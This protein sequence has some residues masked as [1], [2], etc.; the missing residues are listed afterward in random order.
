MAVAANGEALIED[1]EDPDQVP[2]WA[3]LWPAARGMAYYLWKGPQLKGISALELGAGAGLPGVVC[4]LKGAR[5]V[6]SDFQPL[7]LELCEINARLNGLQSYSLLLEDWR[8]YTGRDQFDLVLA[9]DIAYEPRLLPYL[10][11]VLL[12]VL[13]PGGLLYISHDNRP[14]TFAFIEELVA[15]SFI[16]EEKQ[17]IPVNVEDP[18]RPGYHISLHLL[19]K[20]SHNL[21]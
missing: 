12:Q 14:V 13:K 7:A 17:S 9:S 3:E 16:K 21:Y 11:K 15:E 8:S 2:C 1:P 18:I 19:K 6:F 20:A 10:K 4:A 5:V